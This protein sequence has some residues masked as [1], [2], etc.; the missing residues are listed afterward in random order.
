MNNLQNIVIKVVQDFIHTHYETHVQPSPNDI[1]IV[2][3]IPVHNDVVVFKISEDDYFLVTTYRKL[4]RVYVT[5]DNI[6]C[7][8]TVRYTQNQ[9]FKN[10]F[11]EIYNDVA[12]LVIYKS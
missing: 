6:F 2:N 12:K 1:T 7:T 11:H 5:F 8:N 9:T 10:A 4:E 3:D